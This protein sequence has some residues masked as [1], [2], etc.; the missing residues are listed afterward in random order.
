MPFRLIS[1]PSTF[2]R[3]MNHVLK[4]EENTFVLVY[5]DDILIFSKSLDEHLVNLDK[6]LSLLSDYQ[7][8]LERDTKEMNTPFQVGTL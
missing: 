6:V 7:L 4:P 5:L 8:V 1:S 2:Q 3:F